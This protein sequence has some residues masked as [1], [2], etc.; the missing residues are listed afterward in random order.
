[1][2]EVPS[3]CLQARE[4]YKQIDFGSVGSNDLIQYLFAVDRTNEQVSDGYDPHHPILWSIL[5]DLV[6]AA[7]EA[8]KGLSICGEMA[9]REGMVE[10]LLAIGISSLSVSPRLIGQVRREMVRYAAGKK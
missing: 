8:G 1:M 5:Q 6:V 9:G 3:A 7:H 2:F 10:R 4:L